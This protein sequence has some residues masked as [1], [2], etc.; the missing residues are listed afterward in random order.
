M[1]LLHSHIHMRQPSYLLVKHPQECGETGLARLLIELL[2]LVGDLYPDLRRMPPLLVGEPA[3]H[4]EFDSVR[5]LYLQGS[6][7][8]LATPCALRVPQDNS[9][10]VMECLHLLQCDRSPVLIQCIRVS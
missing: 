7:H 9:L 3:P 4:V 1:I 5:V 6:D 2:V 8:A 10:V